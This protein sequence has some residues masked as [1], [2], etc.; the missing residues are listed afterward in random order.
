M[1]TPIETQFVLEKAH[2]ALSGLVDDFLESTYLPLKGSLVFTWSDNLQIGARA[3]SRGSI[4]EP[5]CHKITISHQLA[6]D[7]YRDAES[8]CGFMRSEHYQ[9]SL[10]ATF[11]EL[12]TIFAT[13]N[14]MEKHVATNNMFMASLTWVFFHE[15][16]H[17]M[18]EHKYIR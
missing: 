13:L 7:L 14:S 10:Q 16:G 17:C 2:N 18:Q 5:P 6:I 15:I 12:S 8:C 9:E 11:P 4:N 1:N 3:Y